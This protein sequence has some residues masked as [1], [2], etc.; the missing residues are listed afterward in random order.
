MINIAEEIKDLNELKEIV[1]DLV[2]NVKLITE[3]VKELS[4]NAP[5][6]KNSNEDYNEDYDLN[7]DGKTTPLEIMVVKTLQT[8]ATSQQKTFIQGQK[9]SLWMLLATLAFLSLQVIFAALGIRVSF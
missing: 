1:I 7:K 6:G 5:D 8:I 2:N 9:T 4:E 3:N